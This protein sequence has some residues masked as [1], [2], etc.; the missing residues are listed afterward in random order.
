M[1]P[2]SSY[3][4]AAGIAL[5]Y[6][7][8]ESARQLKKEEATQRKTEPIHSVPWRLLKSSVRSCIQGLQ[9]VWT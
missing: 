2:E 1:D 6:W 4:Q 3:S 8:L 7:N 9:S 5:L